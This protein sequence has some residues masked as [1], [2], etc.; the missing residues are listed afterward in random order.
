MPFPIILI[1][2]LLTLFPSNSCLL[3]LTYSYPTLTLHTLSSYLSSS[4][5]SYIIFSL[6]L[7]GHKALSSASLCTYSHIHSF[8]SYF[9]LL[10]FSLSVFLFLTLHLTP[11][12]VLNTLPYFSHSFFSFP[13]LTFSLSVTFSSRIPK[14]LT[15]F[16]SSHRPD[17]LPFTF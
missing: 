2:L 11:A 17:H 10:L 6:I 15:L 9:H 1:L 4:F 12:F 8:S 3:L 13:L 7:S 5:N 16:F 14:S